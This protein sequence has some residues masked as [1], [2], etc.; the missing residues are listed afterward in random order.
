MNH[1]YEQAA[2]HCGTRPFEGA[3]D[4]DRK[5]AWSLL[6][7]LHDHALYAAARGDVFLGLSDV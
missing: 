4:A 5:P 7:T 1:A 3:D 6:Q 2:H